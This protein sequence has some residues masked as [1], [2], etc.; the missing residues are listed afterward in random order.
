[1]IAHLF[2]DLDGGQLIEAAEGRQAVDDGSYGGGAD[3]GRLRAGFVGR[4]G[5]AVEL[6]DEC[7]DVR[8][9]DAE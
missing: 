1:M 2:E 4:F 8:G 3:P 5:L 6:L 9:R 7:L